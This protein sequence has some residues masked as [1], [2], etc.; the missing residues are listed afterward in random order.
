MLQSSPCQEAL[1]RFLEAKGM[2]GHLADFGM[3]YQSFFSCVCVCVH[4]EWREMIA[5]DAAV[6]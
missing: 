4:A 1:S 2:Q 3:E 6:A 5:I